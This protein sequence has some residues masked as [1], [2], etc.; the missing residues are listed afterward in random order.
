MARKIS[1]NFVS[2]DSLFNYFFILEIYQEEEWS[3]VDVFVAAFV[4]EQIVAVVLEKIVS[5][6]SVVSVEMKTVVVVV[7][8]VGV[9]AEKLVKM[10]S[11]TGR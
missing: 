6:D 1:R 5:A 9:A 2:L 8:E 3:L 7:V 10:M 11:D 4:E